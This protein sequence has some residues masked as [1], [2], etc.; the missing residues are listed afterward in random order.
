MCG[1]KGVLACRAQDHS[2]V[3]PRVVHR[4]GAA[5]NTKAE[6]P[7]SCARLQSDSRN[8]SSFWQISLFVQFVC[9]VAS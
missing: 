8:A 9:A 4:G 5:L 1:I 2:R 3:L 6:V 7:S